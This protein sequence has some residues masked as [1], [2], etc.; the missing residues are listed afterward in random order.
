MPNHAGF[1]LS[2]EGHLNEGQN[3]CAFLSSVDFKEEAWSALI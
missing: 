2:G 3:T 1:N